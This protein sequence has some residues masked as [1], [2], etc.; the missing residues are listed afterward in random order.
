M[1]YPK[2][3]DISFGILVGCLLQFFNFSKMGSGCRKRLFDFELVSA[4][5]DK[6]EHPMKQAK[7]PCYSTQ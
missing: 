4:L 3:W 6:K 7:S 5:S 1:F 2:L